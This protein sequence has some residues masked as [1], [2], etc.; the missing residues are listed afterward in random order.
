MLGPSNQQALAFDD[1]PG[2]LLMAEARAWVADNSDAWESWMDMARSD[3]ARGRCSA[4]FYTEAVRRLHRVRI[5]N[6]YT[7]CFARIALERDP[8]LPFSVNRSKADGFTEAVL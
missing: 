3:K 7:P 8:E 4:K 2:A 6:A 5:K 1:D